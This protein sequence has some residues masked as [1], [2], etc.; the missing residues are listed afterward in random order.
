MRNFRHDERGSITIL[1]AL[2]LPVVLG[3]AALAV[4][5]AHLRYSK[6][7]LQMGA[8]AG[9]LAAIR[10]LSNEADAVQAAVTIANLNVPSNAGNVTAPTDVQLIVYDPG[11]KTYKPSDA[12]TPPTGVRVTA[13]RDEAHGNAIKG[14]FAQLIG[15]SDTY[16]VSASAIAVVRG[17]DDPAC[18][19]ALNAT[20][21]DA[22]TIAGST[23]V[24][25]GC[26][27]RVK[28]ASATAISSNGNKA[29]MT[30]TSVCQANAPGFNPSGFNPT[31]TRC[32]SAVT[33]PFAAVE[34]PTPSGCKPGG[35]LTGTVLAG[36]FSG[37]VNFSGTVT[38]S[39]GTYYFSGS[40][41]NINSNAKITGSGVTLFLDGSSSLKIT[42]NPLIKFSAP[43]SGSLAGISLFQSRKAVGAS[44]TI[45]GNS[46]FNITGAIYAPATVVTF[47]GSGTTTNPARY[48]SLVASKVHFTGNS[49]I[50]FAVAI[51]AGQSGQEG[52]TVG[53]LVY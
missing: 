50:D 32:F 34:E 44:L 23:T 16:S 18:V 41:V 7:R 9:A 46:D 37:P 3:A 52:K 27:V 21:P 6:A 38:L 51:G 24:S 25:L 48:G 53:G 8:D 33:D 15:G 39:A 31:V 47:T 14:I 20:D 45:S 17:T 30:A 12:A 28:S 36:C 29:R 11:T 5:L 35:T 42:G 19:Y 26:G 13:S 1:A 10:K 40:E 43:T 4:D 22:L 2:A 49:E